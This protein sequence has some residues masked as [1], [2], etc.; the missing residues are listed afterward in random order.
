MYVYVHLCV[1][2]VCLSPTY[3]ILIYLTNLHLSWSYTIENSLMISICELILGSLASGF[4]EFSV[5]ISH[6]TTAMLGL[7]VHAMT[8]DSP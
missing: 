7:Q 4:Q 5:S 3:N 1:L 8:F 2:F 6:F